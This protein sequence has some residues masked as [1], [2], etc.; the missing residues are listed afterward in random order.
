MSKIYALLLFA[1]LMVCCTPEDDKPQNK[2]KPPVETEFS[3]SSSEIVLLDKAPY[4]VELTVTASAKWSAQKSDSLDK[5]FDF[6]PSS[7]EAGTTTVVV[8]VKAQNDVYDDRS[9]KVKFTCGAITKTI[10][11]VQKKRD[12]IIISPDE[13][14]VHYDG[15]DINV[16]ARAN[17]AYEV[18][19][20]EK[21]DW[22]RHVVSTKGLD[23]V[24]ERF[25]VDANASK[26]PRRTIIIFK[27]KESPVSDTITVI[28][29]G[30]SI[31]CNYTVQTMGTL[32]T[33]LTQSQKDT[34]IYMKLWGNINA[35]DFATMYNEIA[36]LEYLDLSEVT[37]QD[38]A[39]PDNAFCSIDCVGKQSLSRVTLPKNLVSIGKNAFAGCTSLSGDLVIPSSVTSIGNHAF[40]GC[41]FTGELILPSTLKTIGEGAFMSCDGFTGSLTIPNSV[42]QIGMGAF[43]MCDGFT[44]SLT[45]SSGTKSIGAVAFALTGFKGKL[46][47]AEGVEVIGDGAFSSCFFTG[48]LVL[49]STLRKIDYSAFQFCRGFTGDISIPSSVEKLEDMAFYNCSGFDGGLTLPSGL[50]SIK[51]TT[52]AGCSSLSGNLVIPTS[53][54]SIGDFAFS[55]CEGF[56]GILEIPVAVESIGAQ[57]FWGCDGFSKIKVW[58]TEPIPY[59]E[60]ML[61][62]LK[63]VMVPVSSVAKYASTEGWDGHTIE[64]Y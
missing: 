22:I 39:I 24:G 35:A 40:Y 27:A 8:S 30:V 49:P 16:D 6:T 46:T 3:I 14:L 10:E 56:S 31:P 41:K 34:I 64:W 50:D 62:Y 2:P 55:S 29:N 15:G 12:A 4:Q 54:K 44:G 61:P 47:I 25:T 19:L 7:A 5:W 48:S 18:L 38:N 63:N 9:S 45:L 26:E 51:A 28:Q 32:G 37:I 59:R 36:K 17:V 33:M 42:E 53:V 13:C 1:A 60:W 43:N 52:F 20:T 21:K 11:V 57:A 23:M 58:W